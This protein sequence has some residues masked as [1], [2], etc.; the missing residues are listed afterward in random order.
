MS[1]KKESKEFVV[2]G[3][4]SLHFNEKLMIEKDQINLFFQGEAAGFENKH[5][6]YIFALERKLRCTP[7]YVGKTKK[8]FK[9]E[10]FNAANRRRYESVIKD[11]NGKPKMF[12]IVPTDEVDVSVEKDS[13]VSKCRAKIIV[14]IEGFFI[15]LSACVNPH[16]V[17][18]Q[19]TQGPKW[20]IKGVLNAEQG[21]PGKG[22]LRFKSM[23]KDIDWTRTPKKK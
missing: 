10:I 17:N 7:Y 22:A 21:N 23:F 11:Y 14:E 16:L 15:Q 3:P 5:G 19:K 9:A 6:V 2:K 13:K 1:R 4:F 20:S 18:K 8:S 12:L